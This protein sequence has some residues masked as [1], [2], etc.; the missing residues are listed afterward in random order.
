MP[1][2]KSYQ[3]LNMKTGLKKG[4]FPL[5]VILISL[6]NIKAAT[7]DW[8]GTAS[9]VWTNSSNWTLFSGTSTTNYPVAG[10]IARF[11]VNNTFITSPIIGS[12]ENISCAGI[13]YGPKQAT[14]LVTINGTLTLSTDII[15]N[16]NPNGSGTVS[17]YIKGTGTVS[18]VNIKVGTG[19]TISTT[20]FNLFYSEVK[21][22]NVSGDVNITMTV[23]KPNGT[24][25]RLENGNMYLTGQIKFTTIS[26][27]TNANAAYF[28]VNGT[29]PSGKT[30]PSLY[31][32][33][34]SAVPA[35]P[36][37]VG[38]NNIAT[39]NFNGNRPGGKVSVYYTGANPTVYTTSLVGFGTGGGTI[40]TS[41]PQYDNLII[42][43]TGTATIGSG[44]SAGVLVLDS[45]LTTSSNTTFANATT[46]TTVGTNWQNDATATITGGAGTTT[47]GGNLINA[48]IM[49]MA[50][51]DITV[52]AFTQNTA[53]TLQLGAGNFTTGGVQNSGGTIQG[54]PGPGKVTVGP[55]LFQNNGG[56]YICNAEDL[57]INGDYQNTSIFTAG[58]GTVYFNNTGAQSLSDIS[59]AGTVFNK[60]S[61]SGGALTTPKTMSG[62]GG[63]AVSSTGTL[64]L[65]NNATTKLDAGGVLTLKSDASSTAT[66]T[67]IL[68]TTSTIIGN[69]KVERYFSGGAVAT[70]RGY[71]LGSS[72]V[73]T[74][75]ITN[76]TGATALYSLD[77]LSTSPSSIFTAGPGGTLSGFTSLGAGNS[78]IYLYREDLTSSAAS[79]NGGNF[80]GVNAINTGNTFLVADPAGTGST[81]TTLPAG[82]GYM[83]YYIGDKT[84]VAS[85][86]T[87]SGGKFADPESSTSTATGTINQGDIPVKIWFRANTFLSYTTGISN[88]ISPSFV[89]GFNLVGNPYPS[90]IDWDDFTNGATDP[91]TGIY[92]P[93]LKNS[94]YVFDYR[95]KNYGVYQQGTAGGLGTRNSSHVIVSGQGFFVKVDSSKTVTAAKLTFHEGAK[96]NTQ[97]TGSGLLFKSALVSQ[98]LRIKLSQDSIN[99]DDIILTFEPEAKNEYESDK[100]ADYLQG[101]GSAV[102]LTSYALKSDKK[103]A[104]NHMHSIDES[105]RI[106]LY[107]S[108]SSST[109]LHTLS[110]TGFDSLD[111]RFDVY[112]IDHYKKDS[113]FFSKYKQYLF[114]VDRNDASS[115]GSERFELVF[116]KNSEY[117]YHL[118]GFT[119]KATKD[120]VLLTW[121]VE[122]ETT[123]TSFTIERDN[124]SPLYNVQSDGSGIYTYLD[125]SPL[126][127]VN[128]YRLKQV[129]AFGNITYNT[130]TLN[131]NSQLSVADD[132]FSI[133]PNPVITQFSIKINTP[134]IPKQVQVRVTDLMGN[135][136]INTKNPGDSIRV[137]AYNLLPG[138]YI[139]EVTDS[140]TKKTFGQKKL[141]KQ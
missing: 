90:S 68:N 32:L 127:G 46:T 106:K 115:Y 123:F 124:G 61:F 70:Y 114:H 130:A 37:Q 38:G 48:G 71:R 99:A 29:N 86:V 53:G 87:R 58:T 21:T 138:G 120:G 122:K 93:N 11:G 126:T 2:L 134:A 111:P 26:G 136:V 84:L 22:L 117:N 103:L 102:S 49:N 139:V 82:N 77:F 13:T 9:A 44:A 85:K 95:S 30:N 89:R 54:G 110:A 83:L 50:S 15:V 137:N 121:K 141:I 55:S 101:I 14:N 81:S 113:I 57:Y 112:L 20:A 4:M 128:K 18:C 42:N 31:L 7:F 36:A 107:A 64:S 125:K 108:A 72:A 8:K 80:K 1:C 40:V 76:N 98:L 78:T 63:F 17:S 66:V 129:E 65:A 35:L 74:N 131:F 118:L 104:I 24:G 73:N 109:I 56:T 33:N 97:N 39:V 96:L 5:L 92:G 91:G 52:G 132:F 105:T 10:D 23:N 16:Y 69:V 62:A 12:A 28:T 75:A 6:S 43:G 19:T 47:I 41:T 34:M 135:T 27:I 3:K 116:H 45:A 140:S 119:A 88:Y 133:Y 100:D 79:F 25:F 59:S 51:G 94:V 60:V 67:Q